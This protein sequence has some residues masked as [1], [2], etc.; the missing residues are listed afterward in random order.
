MVFKLQ[1]DQFQCRDGVCI[2]LEN[3]WNVNHGAPVIHFVLLF[4]EKILDKKVWRKAW[5]RGQRRRTSNKWKIRYYC[6]EMLMCFRSLLIRARRIA[7][8]WSFQTKL[9]NSSHEEI[10]TNVLGTGDATQTDETEKFNGFWP[11]PYVWKI[12]LGNKSI[13]ACTQ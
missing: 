3:R 7:R 4:E 1:A 8:L 2:S 5:L 9:Q 11:T 6:Q 12:Y 13:Y 10:N